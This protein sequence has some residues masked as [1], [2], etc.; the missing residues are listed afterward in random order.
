[1]FDIHA[2]KYL[3]LESFRRDGTGVRTPLW[4]AA[5]GDGALYVTSL[6][7]SGKTKRIR[8][9][10]AVRIAPC[11]M[12]GGVT[13]DWSEATATVIEGEGASALLGRKYWPWKQLLNLV[14]RL[15]PRRR[16]TI[17]IVPTAA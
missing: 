3:S 9:N 1:M 8:R 10:S 15:R 17:R 14:S 6:W 11:G 2:E 5:G 13:G 16:C 7:D 12:L 4:F